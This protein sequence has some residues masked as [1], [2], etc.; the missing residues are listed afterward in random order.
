MPV[1]RAKGQL[2]IPALEQTA[3]SA[4]AKAA[5]L[6]MGWK[7]RHIKPLCV[8]TRLCSEFPLLE[9]RHGTISLRC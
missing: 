6:P 3:R 4:A 1:L 9:Y 8:H 5:M 2:I 7:L